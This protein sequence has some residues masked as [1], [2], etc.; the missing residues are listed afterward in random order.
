MTPPPRH[1]PDLVKSTPSVSPASLLPFRC[2]LLSGLPTVSLILSCVCPRPAPVQSALH[3]QC[4][5]WDTFPPDR[6]AAWRGSMPPP[7]PVLLIQSE[8][9]QAWRGRL[10][11]SSLFIHL[12]FVLISAPFPSVLQPGHVVCYEVCGLPCFRLLCAL[13]PT[14]GK[15]SP[16]T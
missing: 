8:L 14:L 7:L 1:A 11:L 12:L 6:S 16:H 5:C 13:F 9:L 4:P 3:S 2:H 15:P 10:Q